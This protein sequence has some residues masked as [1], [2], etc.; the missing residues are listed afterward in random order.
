MKLGMKTTSQAWFI[1]EIEIKDKE[2]R[3]KTI[4]LSRYQ[5]MYKKVSKR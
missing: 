3:Y 5:N 1:H 4:C 2:N